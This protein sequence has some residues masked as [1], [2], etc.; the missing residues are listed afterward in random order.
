MTKPEVI[1]RRRLRRKR[2]RAI[3]RAVCMAVLLT[4]IVAVLR[5]AGNRLL[6]TDSIAKPESAHLQAASAVTVSRPVERHSSL[7]TDDLKNYSKAGKTAAKIY[8]NRNQYSETLLAAYLNN[9][10]M[11]EFIDGYLDA[12]LPQYSA[13][14][15]LTRQELRQDFPLFLQW[16]KRWGYVSYGGSIIGLSGCGP[17]CMSMVLVSLT[18][19]SDMT[20]AEVARFSEENGYYVEGSGTS[21][22]LMTDG[23]YALGLSARELSLDESVMKSS[24]DSGHPIICS[25]GPGDFTTQGHFILIYGYDAEGFLVNDPN[26]ISRSSRHWDFETLR[27]QIKNLWAYSAL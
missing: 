8:K 11:E 26:C 3:K 1:R 4:G 12:D 16:D 24:L 21:W 20:P 22:S 17:T 5:M 19:S 7:I 23:A 18:G 14:G 2:R 13:Q 6:P 25:M 27:G 15:G 10:E 9:P